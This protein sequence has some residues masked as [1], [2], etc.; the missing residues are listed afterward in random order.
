MGLATQ[1]A[2][3]QQGSKSRIDTPAD[4]MLIDANAL[5]YA[6]M[7]TPL[8]QLEHQGFPTGGMHGLLNSIFARMS[9]RPSAV[10]VVLWDSKAQWR[11]DL[12][13]EYKGTRFATPEKQAIR[14]SYRMQTPVVR[15]ILTA[16]GI[17]Q[18]ACGGAEADDLAGV[19]CRHIDPSWAVE[20]VTG[21][22]DW[23]QALAPNASWFSPVHKMSVTIESLSDP[24]TG[25]KD[26]HFLS[27]TEY[28][29][30]KALTGDSSDEIPG[31][32]K[33]GM[34]TAAKT[35]RAS[36][37][38]IRNFWAGVA[39]GDIQPKGVIAERLASAESQA[40]FERN[41][42]L[43]DWSLAPEIDPGL[44]AVTAGKPDWQ[45]L[46]QTAEDFGLKKVHSR[47]M[48]ALKPWAGGWGDGLWAVDAALNYRMCQQNPRHGQHDSA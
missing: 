12:L 37:G 30:C 7:Y 33:I 14:E 39:S 38:D 35:I 3:S 10:P 13:P 40:L 29:Q 42:K 16:L 41:I 17:P 2:P 23:W 5:G 1:E 27:T 15:I 26:G 44:L 28:L 6:A 24:E 43:M 20:M 4:I 45:T 22:T 19:I 8:G 34:R 11:Y 36:G 21:D 25:L 32:E 31:I 46:S 9:D 18:V 47:A 48:E